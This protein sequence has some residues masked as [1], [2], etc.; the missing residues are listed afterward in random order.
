[1]PIPL[2]W[3][4][5]RGRRGRWL[6]DL[7]WIRGGV[8][9]FAEER[10]AVAS[11]DGDLVYLDGLDRISVSLAVGVSEV[12]ITIRTT[13]VDWLDGWRRGGSLE[14]LPARL[15]RWYE[16]SAY[17]DARLVV[18]G[19]LVSVSVADPSTPG[20]LSGTLAVDALAESLTPD[21]IMRWQDLRSADGS[22]W[23]MT[24]ESPSNGAYRPVVVGRPGAPTG[25]P[26]VPAYE[27]NLTSATLGPPALIPP[28]WLLAGHAL[29]ASSVRLWDMEGGSVGATQSSPDL[30]P[31]QSDR[32][33]QVFAQILRVTN[34]SP[35]IATTE[36][37]AGARVNTGRKFWWGLTTTDA[38][39][40]PYRDGGLRGL[41]DVLRWWYE[42]RGGRTV[43]GASC[44]AFSGPLNQYRIDFA[45]T[46]PV[47]TDAWVEAEVLRVYPVRVIHGPRGVYFRRRTYQAT[48]AD[49]VATLSTRGLGIEVAASSPLTPVDVSLVSHVRVEYGHRTL[50]DYLY[51]AEIGVQPSTVAVES[52]ASV[53]GEGGAH[54]AEVAAANFGPRTATLQVPTTWDDTTAN[55]VALDYLDRESLP[56]YRRTYQGG[57]EI[58]GL[59]VGDVV[60]LDDEQ[61]SPDQVRLATVEDVRL[62]GSLVTI[63]VEILRDPLAYTVPTS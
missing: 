8:L 22:T 28:S 63:T 11:D 34:D 25:I 35:W 61:L 9:R 24:E 29:L 21:Q 1:M 42:Y 17:E 59:A 13:D 23:A 26:A 41:G 32:R 14:R 52:Y 44:E 18:D 6:L 33:D 53:L 55:L 10:V 15:W 48:D 37:T 2:H 4:Q 50:S 16:G 12:P 60:A 56:R 19:L 45:W 51:V 20:A 54:L 39:A 46:S 36:T 47:T 58:E 5:L 27:L 31:S 57:A 43:D 38:L 3:T 40:N 7:E 62:G 30:L 49:V